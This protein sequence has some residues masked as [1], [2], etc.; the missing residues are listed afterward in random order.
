MP[1]PSSILEERRAAY[2]DDY[3]GRPRFRKFLPFLPPGG[4]ILDI[5]SHSGVLLNFL[6]ANGFRAV[7]IDRDPVSVS[8]CRR[9]G[10]EVIEGDVFEVLE[11]PGA[12]KG[13]D[14]IF[15]SDFVEHLDCRE[16]RR[17]LRI[18]A[19]AIRPG[20]V[21]V[22][23]T[24]NSRNLTVA[25]GGIWEDELEHVRPYPL[26]ALRREM[27]RLGLETLAAGVEPES[28]EAFWS[29]WPG[30]LLRNILRAFLARAL[31]G[32][33]WRGTNASIVAR[34]PVTG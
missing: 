9:L 6:E 28:R 22:I 29:P 5:G 10:F 4:R 24:P 16:A 11:G 13:F 32:R 12:P 25:L 19:G 14:G 30:V 23:L 33:D 34:R 18:A 21:V 3:F 31:M 1:I 2:G 27:E 8:R 20:G 26:S 15:I 7:G 17:L